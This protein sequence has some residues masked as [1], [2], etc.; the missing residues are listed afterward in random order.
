MKYTV[1]KSS[2]GEVVASSGG[3]IIEM[4]PAGKLPL[5]AFKTALLS[6][7]RGEVARFTLQPACESSP[8]QPSITELHRQKFGL[9]CFPFTIF[10]DCDAKLEGK[11]ACSF[12]CSFAFDSLKL[13]CNEKFALT[14]CVPMSCTVK[15][16][17]QQC[18]AS[19]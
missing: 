1:K 13:S 19:S 5:K 16:P 10:A 3:A 11:R 4:S 17:A 6:M 8:Y 18:T 15:A 9:S 14:A 7:Q 2:N 12:D